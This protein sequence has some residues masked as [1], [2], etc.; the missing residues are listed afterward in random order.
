MTALLALI[1]GLVIGGS[2]YAGGLATRRDNELSVTALVQLA[3]G[4]TALVVAFVYPWTA[5]TTT[6]LVAGAIAGVSGV[7]SFV[8]FYRALSTG[9]MGVVA[10]LT[11]VIGAVVPAGISIA[12][13]ERLSTVATIG[14]VIAVVGI[15]LVSRPT[16]DS[17]R[18]TTTPP[19]ALILSVVA[20]LGFSLFF[21]ALART[22][23][24]A[25][26]WPLVSAR[27]VS[28]P[29]VFAASVVVNKRVLPLAPAR[30]L[31]IIGG[32]NEMLANVMILVAIQRGPVAIATV[33]GAFYPIST[34]ALAYMF[35]GE[36][37]G[38]THIA[39]AALAVCAL[40]LVAL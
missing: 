25:G 23:S 19:S 37:L 3:S 35:L 40:P 1:S 5:I 33:F 2:D 30:R 26:V 24:D 7:F 32:I 14:L 12:G 38:R 15:L 10:P 4:L 13:G 27:A 16:D 20:G 17:D 39:G 6:D 36:R 18:T 9:A 11:A 34:A 8:A 28:V 21:L 29:I 22:S 31:A